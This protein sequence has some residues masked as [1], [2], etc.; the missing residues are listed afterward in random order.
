MVKRKSDAVFR[1]LFTKLQLEKPSASC[2]SLHTIELS[3]LMKLF[4][5]VPN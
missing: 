5:K 3:V 2:I 4:Q 1:Y